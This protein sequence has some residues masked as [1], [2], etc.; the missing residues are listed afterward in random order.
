MNR[1]LRFTI[2]LLLT[3]VFFLPILFMIYFSFSAQQFIK[4]PISEFSIKWYEIIF[5]NSKLIESI[6]YSIIV[7]IC[8]VLFCIS[9]GL[10]AAYSILIFKRAKKVFLFIYT[11]PAVIPFLLYGLSFFKYSSL[12]G[13]S[14]SLFAVILSHITVFLPFTI[15][16]FYYNLNKM[17]FNIFLAGKEIGLNYI[18]IIIYIIRKSLKP[19]ILSASFLVF[20]LSWD[21]Y[22][23]TW[24]MSGFDK[25]YSVAIKN[26]L[27]STFTPVVFSIGTLLFIITII[28]LPIIIGQ[29]NAFKDL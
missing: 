18:E 8:V 14:G 22:I 7:G 5:S 13:F 12:I 4:F 15:F 21:E 25:P 11:L 19:Q 27:D 9:L 10:V 20:V 26:I 6:G 16:Y 1:F 3:L 24:F 28:I 29:M 2:V 23:L 17:S